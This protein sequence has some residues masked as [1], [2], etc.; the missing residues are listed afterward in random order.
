MTEEKRRGRTPA[1]LCIKNKPGVGMSYIAKTKI[2][3]KYELIRIATTCARDTNKSKGG[4]L[5]GLKLSNYTN[6]GG[7]NGERYF[8]AKL[9]RKGSFSY[10]VFLC[11][12]RHTKCMGFEA[13]AKDIPDCIDKV[14]AKV[15]EDKHHKTDDKGRVCITGHI[16]GLLE[17]EWTGESYKEAM[18]AGKKVFKITP[19][20]EFEL[21]E[22][23][24]EPTAAELKKRAERA[25]KKAAKKEAE[26]KA[27]KKEKKAPV[28]KAAEVAK[29]ANVAK[30]KKTD[31][32]KT[33]YAIV[34]GKIVSVR[35]VTKPEGAF[36]SRAEAESALTVAVD[37][38]AAAIE[39]APVE[40]ENAPAKAVVETAEEVAAE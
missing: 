32:R 28:K 36:E 4:E 11:D 9:A 13:A 34:D 38:L 26:E 18:L 1:N 39:H 21:A 12:G 27:E 14:M 23:K 10:M 25:A 35:K 37:M 30:P 31:N 3:S 8:T 17:Y 19:D 16:D 40:T 7:V 15:A 33:F 22:L 6:G 5:I 20:H 29:E 2:K 24:A